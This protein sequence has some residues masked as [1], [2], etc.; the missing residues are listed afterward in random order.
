MSKQARVTEIETS[1]KKY[2]KNLLKIP[3]PPEKIYIKGRMV[4]GEI[5]ALFENCIGVVGSRSMTSY[6]KRVISSVFAELIKSDITVV[7][8]FMYGVDIESHKNALKYGIKTIAVMPCGIDLINPPGFRYVYDMILESGGLILS[9]YNGKIP[10]RRYTYVRRNRIIAGLSKAVLAV[11]ASLKSGTLITA[12]FA[13]KYNKKIFTIPGSIFSNVFQG[14]YQ[15]YKK[16]AEF[17]ISGRRIREFFGLNL[18]MKDSQYKEKGEERFSNK[19]TNS[20]VSK[21][22]NELKPKIYQALLNESMT[23]D[24]LEEHLKE[25][26]SKILS[27]LTFMVLEGLVFEEGGKY[28]ANKS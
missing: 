26:V 5:Q 11:E 1:S 27:N 4:K 19:K 8:G 6:G 16:G 17:I 12:D 9:E 25:P 23:I 18:G 2:P 14:N 20:N 15:L 21:G 7:S 10:P 13:Q 22:K 28:N 3:D 24:D